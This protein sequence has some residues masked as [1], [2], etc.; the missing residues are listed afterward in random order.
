MPPPVMDG[1]AKDSPKDHLYACIRHCTS[2]FTSRH[3]PRVLIACL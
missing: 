2:P 3:T 1:L